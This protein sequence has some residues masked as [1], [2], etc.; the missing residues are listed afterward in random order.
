MLGAK[1]GL[2]RIKPGEDI[3]DFLGA[4]AGARFLKPFAFA[5]EGSLFTSALRQDFA[6]AA[7][8]LFIVTKEVAKSVNSASRARGANRRRAV[9]EP[10]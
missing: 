7:G 1:I 6:T 3:R 5:R 2:E 8:S 4:V 9:H 10:N